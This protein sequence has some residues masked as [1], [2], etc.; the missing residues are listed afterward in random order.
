MIR[1]HRICHCFCLIWCFCCSVVS[2][3]IMLLFQKNLHCCFF[4]WCAVLFLLLYCVINVATSIV[5]VLLP[6]VVVSIV[7]KCCFC[8][9][10]VFF[11]VVVFAIFRLQL[12]FPLS[13]SRAPRNVKPFERKKY[14]RKR[15]KRNFWIVNE[16]EG[17]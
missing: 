3:C 1:V 11:N 8:C 7:V 4:N 12:Q 17:N 5:M 2:Y 13:F 10:F 14:F 15:K 16:I 9:C 6:C